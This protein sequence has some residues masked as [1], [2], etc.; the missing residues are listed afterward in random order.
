MAGKLA[1][2]PRQAPQPEDIEVVVWEENLPAAVLFLRM[3]TQRR[4][5]GMGAFVGFDYQPLFGF[6]DRDHKD[7]DAWEAA[8]ADFRIMESAAVEAANKT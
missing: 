2:M 4:Y 8:F 3:F 7:R 5:A 6:L 1:E